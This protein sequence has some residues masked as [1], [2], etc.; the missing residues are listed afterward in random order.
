M[1][2]CLLVTIATTLGAAGRAVGFLSTLPRTVVDFLGAVADIFGVVTD[3]LE[4]VAGVLGAV[5]NIPGVI[6]DILGTIADILGGWG[7][8]TS[9]PSRRH[10]QPHG[11]TTG[12]RYGRCDGR[13]NSSSSL[14]TNIESSSLSPSIRASVWLFLK[15]V[16]R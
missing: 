10:S 1:V 11:A 13:G 9:C 7:G 3:I 5:T 8:S 2:I 15:Q 4:T 14:G 12:H 6:T 16:S